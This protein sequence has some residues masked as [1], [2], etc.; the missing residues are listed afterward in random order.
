M[1]LYELLMLKNIKGKM[2]ISRSNFLLCDALKENR[3]QDK[4]LLVCRGDY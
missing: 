4:L 2:K 1:N 3:T